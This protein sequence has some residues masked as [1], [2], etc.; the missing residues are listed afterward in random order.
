[1]SPNSSSMQGLGD[2][3]PGHAALGSVGFNV[4]AVSGDAIDCEW[5][6]PPVGTDRRNISSLID[7]SGINLSFGLLDRERPDIASLARFAHRI[8]LATFQ[9]CAAF[10][11][12]GVVDFRADAER[13]GRNRRNSHGWF[14]T[15]AEATFRRFGVLRQALMHDWT[16]TAAVEPLAFSAFNSLCELT[17]AASHPLKVMFFSHR[18]KAMKGL[19]GQLD[20]IAQQL[21]EAIALAA[22]LDEG[23]SD[24]AHDGAA[25]RLAASQAAILARSGEALTLT[26]AAARLGTTRQNVHKRIG[27]GS[28]LGVMRG[29]RSLIVPSV[30]FVEED[31][32]WNIVRDLRPV[33][34][35]FEMQR[36][37]SWSALQF[38]TEHDPILEGVPIEELK[39][40]QVDKV[41][42]A[43]RAYLGVEEA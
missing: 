3:A 25:A 22:D 19:V 11:Q 1:M 33:L 5:I 36:A 37:G 15:L 16:P 8:E 21:Q 42:A 27:V 13:D 34:D 9:M 26:K 38:L 35:V 10:E 28:V 14:P 4:S 23:D 40:G 6:A 24:P 17:P 18:S 7:N 32:K 30:Q 39:A 31:G 41:V 12:G 43:A 20:L 29:S 2:D